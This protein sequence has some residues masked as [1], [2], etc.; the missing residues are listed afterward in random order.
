MNLTPGSISTLSTLI[1][2]ATSACNRPAQSTQHPQPQP[3][4]KPVI[5]TSKA[6][7]PAGP[8]A[9]PKDADRLP[10]ITVRMTLPQG[11]QRILSRTKDRIHLAMP[12]RNQEWL[13]IRNPVDG[14]RVSGILI[15]HGHKV[16]IDYPESDLRIEGVARGWADLLSIDENNG[17]VS[18]GVDHSLLQDP[19]KR[20]PTYGD[21]DIAD[22]REE[23]HENGHDHAGHHPATDTTPKPA[24]SH[25]ESEHG[26]PHPKPEHD[27]PHPKPE[28][29]H[30]HP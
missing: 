22:W 7:T 2:L 30:P 11:E 15:D 1:L 14:R 21:F 26:H 12:D 28:H 17:D 5:R 23:L 16:R 20:F 9:L 24:T 10:E 18:K 3:E 4:P 13:F 6:E 25:P 19:R 29:D 27:H 8:P